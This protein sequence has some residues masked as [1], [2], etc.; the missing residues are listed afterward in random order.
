VATFLRA[1]PLAAGTRWRLLPINANGQPAF[2]EYKW[3]ET[4]ERFVAEAVTVLTI[5]D[6]LVA[7]ITAFRGPELFPHFGLPE[8]LEP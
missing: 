6:A 3:N 1:L 4:T 7:D 2:G 8:R 5:A